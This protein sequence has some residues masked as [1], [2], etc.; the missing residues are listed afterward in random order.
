MKQNKQS[1]TLS[2]IIREPDPSMNQCRLMRADR[3][4][5]SGSI[6]KLPGLTPDPVQNDLILNELAQ[7]NRTGSF[8]GFRPTFSARTAKTITGEQTPREL[9]D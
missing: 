1:I 3:R 2:G 7:R 5:L 8:P 6:R 9:F 4:L